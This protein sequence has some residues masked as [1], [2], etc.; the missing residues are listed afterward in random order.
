MNINYSPRKLPQF[1][2]WS[3]SDMRG[4]LPHNFF[5][6]IK[7]WI[8]NWGFQYFL[9]HFLNQKSGNNVV[10]MLLQKLSKEFNVNFSRNLN[11]Y[12]FYISGWDSHLNTNLNGRFDQIFPSK[13]GLLNPDI[14]QVIKKSDICLVLI[15]EKENVN[16]GIF[17][18]IEGNKGRKLFSNSFW[19]DRSDYCVY[20]FG[21]VKGKSKACYAEVYYYNSAPKVNIIFEADNFV[22]SDFYLS[23]NK[24]EMLFQSGPSYYVQERDEEFG[25]FM[26]YFIKHWNTPI[27]EVL[28]FMYKFIDYN[29]YIGKVDG[30][31]PF[32]SSLQ[33]EKS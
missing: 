14:N 12:W 28:D 2:N 7:N 25:F 20:S 3:L 33:A 8:Y 11:R 16:L 29:D 21:V 9:V 32:M 31:L 26:D 10:E 27:I 22:V 13:A 15:N 23:V 18:E 19:N 4:N 24:I 17:G 30:S 6:N 5:N 1:P